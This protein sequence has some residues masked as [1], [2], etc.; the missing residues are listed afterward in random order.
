MY[1]WQ[2]IPMGHLAEEF[3][4]SLNFKIGTGTKVLTADLDETLDVFKHI[5]LVIISSKGF[6]CPTLST[7]RS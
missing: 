7:V 2:Q 3:R 6:F 1:Q 4:L 5:W